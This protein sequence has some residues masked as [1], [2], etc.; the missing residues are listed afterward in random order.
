MLDTI[1][2]LPEPYFTGQIPDP[3][4]ASTPA[5]QLADE[6]ERVLASDLSLGLGL[7][8]TDVQLL[9][10]YGAYHNANSLPLAL[11]ALSSMYRLSY[12]EPWELLQEKTG[13]ITARHIE[14]SLRWDRSMPDCSGREAIILAKRLS[15]RDKSPADGLQ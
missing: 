14:K 9:R 5:D 4:P 6:I 11:R 2:Q 7:Q 10:W 12:F 1:Q 3:A 13:L 8:A 15:T